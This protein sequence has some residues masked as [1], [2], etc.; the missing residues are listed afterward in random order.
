MHGFGKNILQYVLCI[1]SK[2]LVKSAFEPSGSSRPS[3][4][5]FL[6]NEAFTNTPTTTLD[7]LLVHRRFTPSINFSCTHFYTCVVWNT[8]PKWGSLIVM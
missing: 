8:Q 4:N 3:L 5:W 1:K 2:Y 6:Y 7:G